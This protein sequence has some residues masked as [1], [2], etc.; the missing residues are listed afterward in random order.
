MSKLDAI[1]PPDARA[2]HNKWFRNGTWT[3]TTWRGVAAQKCP[4]DLWVYQEII[5]EKQPA[6]VVELGT[7]FG[8]SALFLADVMESIGFGR[9]ITID[10]DST[11]HDE[12]H[13][14]LQPHPRIIPIVGSS[15]D[16][17]L[18]DKVKKEHFYGGA[19]MVIADSDHSEQHVL[20]ELRLWGDV[21][22]PGQYFI[23]EDTN[24]AVIHN[25]VERTPLA[26]VETF[27]SER[28]DFTADRSREKHLL[29]QNPK[30]Y[31]LRT[32]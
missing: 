21:V 7:R 31:L 17:S 9:V 32:K 3:T 10:I 2:F 30:G 16:R 25:R 11:Y 28:S 14:K 18:F 20:K 13:A 5:W 12:F 22:T 29:T 6:I 27:L 1:M 26:A 23:V 19:V 24:H 8:G 15:A 4:L